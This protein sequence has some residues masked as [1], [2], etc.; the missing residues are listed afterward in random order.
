MIRPNTS[1]A[2][3]RAS[4][5]PTTSHM[6]WCTWWCHLGAREPTANRTWDHK[7]N[8]QQ[9]KHADLWGGIT[10]QGWKR[11]S[12]VLKCS[13][14]QAIPGVPMALVALSTHPLSSTRE[15]VPKSENLNRNANSGACWIY[16]SLTYL[17]MSLSINEKVVRLDIAVCMAHLKNMYVMRS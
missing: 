15:H 6:S 13:H 10:Y 5:Q 2:S 4:H 12:T 3:R 14:E 11:S 7:V 1:K 9:G 17:E 16:S 8:H